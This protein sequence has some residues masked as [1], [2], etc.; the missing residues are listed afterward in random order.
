M[1]TLVY[2]QYPTP[3]RTTEDDMRAVAARLA[4][5][6][7]NALVNVVEDPG[8]IGTIAVTGPVRCYSA[9]GG[10]VWLYFGAETLAVTGD[11]LHLL[12]VHR[13]DVADPDMPSGW[14]AVALRAM[15]R[16]SARPRLP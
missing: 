13:S 3:P 15:R 4:P 1:R 12:L 7:L 10:L 11:V 14:P 9:G 8:R 5:A 16:W 2:W 6:A